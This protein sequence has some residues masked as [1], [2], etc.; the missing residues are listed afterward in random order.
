MRAKRSPAAGPPAGRARPCPHGFAAIRLGKLIFI[1][2]E[3]A[4]FH[5]RSSG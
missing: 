4:C 2:G 1:R 5:G 3:I